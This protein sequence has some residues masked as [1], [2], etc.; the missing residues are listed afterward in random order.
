MS[1]STIF[2]NSIIKKLLE[3]R[4]IETGQD[5]FKRWSKA[6]QKN[7]GFENWK[8]QIATSNRAKM[9]RGGTLIND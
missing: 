1:A 5:Y 4:A 2:A 7:G 6:R 9:G 3:K 8:S